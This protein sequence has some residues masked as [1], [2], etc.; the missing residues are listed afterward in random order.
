MF[1]I[2]VYYAS[3]EISWQLQVCSLQHEHKARVVNLIHFQSICCKKNNNNLTHFWLAILIYVFLITDFLRS[4][5]RSYQK[6]YSFLTRT[7]MFIRFIE[8][9]SF[10]S[11]LDAGLAFFDECSEK[12]IAHWYISGASGKMFLANAYFLPIALTA[13]RGHVFMR[14]SGLLKKC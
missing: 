14:L 9:R 6:F 5:D 11:D 1:C 8:E 12:V 10:V 4:R 7:Q 13:R 3:K 2:I